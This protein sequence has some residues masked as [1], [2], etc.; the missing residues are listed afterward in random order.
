M[1]EQRT[2]G[3]RFWFTTIW[4]FAPFIF[5]IVLIIGRIFEVSMRG[6]IIQA[7]VMLPLVFTFRGRLA[8]MFHNMADW[9][10]GSKS[11]TDKESTLWY[12]LFL[13]FRS[14][15]VSV[16]EGALI[17]LFDSIGLLFL[18]FYYFVGIYLQHM[19]G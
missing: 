11:D 8:T 19:A 7:F 1:T 10:H 2:I 5:A 12:K 16:K 6:L 4:T 18:L 14:S 17:S 15:G 9:A 3:S 13:S